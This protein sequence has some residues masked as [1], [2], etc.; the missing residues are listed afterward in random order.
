LE[1]L[2]KIHKIKAPSNTAVTKKISIENGESI[3]LVF[4]NNKYF[5]Y[6]NQCQHLPVEL[7]WDNEDFFDEKKQYI[8][9]ATHGALYEP[10]TGLCISGPCVGKILPSIEVDVDEEF[11]SLKLRNKQNDK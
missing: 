11:I 4:F 9:C 8:V 5:A 1:Q 2:I 6:K 10:E 7:D 3:I